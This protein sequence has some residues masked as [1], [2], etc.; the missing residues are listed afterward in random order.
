MAVD[1]S[2]VPSAFEHTFESGHRHR[3]LPMC[4]GGIVSIIEHMFDGK[5]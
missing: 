2:A 4:T 1:C 3:I 5:A